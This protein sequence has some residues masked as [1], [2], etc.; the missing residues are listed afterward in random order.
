MQNQANFMEGLRKDPRLEQTFTAA[1]GPLV[2]RV[3][4]VVRIFYPNLVAN[5]LVDMQ[6]LDRQNGEIFVVTPVYSNTA[7]G[8]NAGETVFK[9]Q[10]DG[11]Y[12]SERV[13]AIG[14]PASDGIEVTFTATLTP[15]P[16]RPGSVIVTAGTITGVDDGNG[17]VTGTGI[18]TGTIVYATGAFSVTFDAAPLTGVAVTIQHRYNMEENPDLIRQLEIKLGTIPV[19]AEPHPL[20]VTWSTQA[21]LAASAHLDLDIPDILANLVGSFIKQERDIKLVSQI[22]AAATV[23][24]QLDFDASA[25]AGYSK[26][27]RYAEF[28]TKLNYAESAIQTA[29]GRGGLSFVM[30]GSNV[31][32]VLRHVNGF[33]DAGATAPIGP[34]RCGTIRDGT[35][36]VVKVP[37]M[38]P[39]SYTVGFKGYVVGDS[40]TILAEWVPLYASP[41]FQSY[42][43]NNYQG[44]MSLY[45]L[46][47]NNTS[48]YRKGTM[49]GYT[50]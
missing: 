42:D 33:S 19:T 43:L 40:A 44:L 30:A 34:Y 46:V 37:T 13:N 20:R 6:P 21:Q 38:N 36:P 7:A 16:M 3:I 10:T 5:D 14:A 8:V 41:V 32:D 49:T 31:A 35:V 39:N 11:T 1:L 22:A 15:L 48:Y 23:D 28:E 26:I 4:D 27:A 9:D 2:P 29:N 25:P 47:M 45:A 24:A 50:A 17:N 18:A 12:A